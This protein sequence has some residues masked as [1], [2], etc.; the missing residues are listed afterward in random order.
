M[1]LRHFAV[2]SCDDCVGMELSSARLL[3]EHFSC[4]YG[5]R[6]SWS[7]YERGETSMVGS[8]VI[9]RGGIDSGVCWDEE[10]SDIWCTGVSYDCVGVSTES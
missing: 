2:I 3:C 10:V 7:G 1:T 9:R 5:W 8:A 6:G 4:A